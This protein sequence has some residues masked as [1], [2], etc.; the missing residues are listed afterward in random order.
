MSMSIENKIN[1]FLNK[2][3]ILKK[4]VKSAYQLGMYSISPKIKPQGHI[5]S[6]SS[7][8]WMEY[9]FG[10]YDKSP[11]DA[12]DRYMLCL[13]AKDTHSSVATKEPADIIL[14][15]TKDNNSYKV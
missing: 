2:A 12:T 9:F 3:P 7:Y 13:R 5:Q 4:I 8:D 11:L 10:Y 14:F 15:D 6:I 1:S